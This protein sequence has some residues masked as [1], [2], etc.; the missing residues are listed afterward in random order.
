MK[1]QAT[2]LG[3]ESDFQKVLFYLLNVHSSEGKIQCS[4]SPRTVAGFFTAGATAAGCG[5]E[6]AARRRSTITTITRPNL[7]LPA[8][9]QLNRVRRH[10]CSLQKVA[11]EPSGSFDGL[12]PRELKLDKGGVPLPGCYSAAVVAVVRGRASEGKRPDG[13]VPL[14]EGG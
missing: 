3:T 14:S 9:S 11:H 4:R 5:G 12:G 13:G 1:S 6:G 8:T 2:S 10:E 7:S